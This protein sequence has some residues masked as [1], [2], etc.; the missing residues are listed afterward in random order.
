MQKKFSFLRVQRGAVLSACSM[1]SL[2]VLQGCS[3]VLDSSSYSAPQVEMVQ[4]WRQGNE[5]PGRKDI[6]MSDS[7]WLS[8][9][10]PT[11][12]A[13][14]DEALQKNSDL[15]LA[16]LDVQK[17]MLEAGLAKNDQFPQVSA[18]AS[19]EFDRDVKDW[20]DGS[21]RSFTGSLSVSY[22]IDLWN[23][24]KNT[25]R[26]ARLEALAT[27]E[28]RN[29]VR[30]SLTGSVANAYFEIC[31]LKER[32]QLSSD[33]IAYA[34][35]SLE[36]VQVQKDA[37]AATSLEVLEA[38]QNLASQEASHTTLV[39][40]LVEARHTLALLFDGP[41]E[42]LKQEDNLSLADI[43]LPSVQPGLPSE[44]LAR[45][46][47]VR[48]AE[49]RVEEAFSSSQVSRASMYPSFSLTGA[50]GDSSEDLS[51]LFSNPVASLAA[52]ISLPFL[53]WDDVQ[54]NIKISDIA[55]KEAVIDY[56]DTLYTALSEVENSL[57][58][59]KQYRLQE[60]KLDLSLD[61]AKKTEAIY[62]TRYTT[63]S[64]TMKT[65]LD[66]QEERRDAEVDLAEN[67]LDQLENYVT[68]CKAL[69]G[70]PK[71]VSSEK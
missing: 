55:Y 59:R 29:A 30:L 26:A 69:G 71:E 2:L 13:L 15:T 34:K 43:E 37:G 40:E 41:P 7:W 46:P 47:D 31:Y 4:S 57:S 56:R 44:L 5:E 51:R 32:L 9:H 45:R 28:D 49:L 23:E 62:N 24:L 21:S 36:L 12:N 63:G 68:L 64:V 54:K 20:G 53:Q 35:R 11:L 60:E 8:L 70:E 25:T 67:R 61:R 48:A 39:Q 3:P 10:D 16:M 18:D 50:L 66:A 52:S 6:T 33:S 65:W 42:H 22:E 14:M 58:A 38:E 27:E 19:G 17:A 1:A